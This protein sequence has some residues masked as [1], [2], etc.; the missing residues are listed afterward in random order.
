M[1]SGSWEGGGCRTLKGCA[2]AGGC[3]G[4]KNL[5]CRCVTKKVRFYATTKKCSFQDEQ[6]ETDPCAD[7]KC[8]NNAKC[9][10]KSGQESY[11]C[12]CDDMFE[13]ALC[14][15]KSKFSSLRA[16]HK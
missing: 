1:D 5:A 12:I 4:G 14:E 15:A 16:S 8:Q 3:R 11:E 10:A 9:Q 13:G 7:H 2:A 6:P